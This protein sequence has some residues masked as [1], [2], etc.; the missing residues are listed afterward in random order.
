M[1]VVGSRWNRSIAI[2]PG[3]AL[4]PPTNHSR[5]FIIV[6]Y[7]PSSGLI[8]HTGLSISKVLVQYRGHTDTMA[9]NRNVWY[10][11]YA[12]VGPAKIT[13]FARRRLVLT[14]NVDLKAYGFLEKSYASVK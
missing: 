12:P 8:L 9:H 10:L 5:P 1:F 2:T 7:K 4:P 14:D 6:D 13:L 11:D 3:I